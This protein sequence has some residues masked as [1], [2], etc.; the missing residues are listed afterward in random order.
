[1]NEDVPTV[2]VDLVKSS[3]GTKEQPLTIGD[4]V[5]KPDAATEKQKE[6]DSIDPVQM[7]QDARK[8]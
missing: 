4:K 1:L 7:I 8:V 3:Y 5:D 2:P 6:K